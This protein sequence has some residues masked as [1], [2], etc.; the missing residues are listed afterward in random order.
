MRAPNARAPAVAAA[1]APDQTLPQCGRDSKY[2][3]KRFA[4]LS[5]A[6]ALQGV[7]LHR[8]EGGRLLVT[9]WGLTREL[10]TIDDAARFLAEMGIEP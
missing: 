2:R 3:A 10:D 9:R 1:E 8:L 6:A 5:A 4:T 7:Q